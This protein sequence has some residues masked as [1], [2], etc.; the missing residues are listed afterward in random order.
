[1]YVRNTSQVLAKRLA[2]SRSFI[3]IVIGPRQTGKTTAIRQ[4]V[5]ASGR[6]YRVANADGITVPP[7][8]WVETEWMQARALATSD[9]PAILVLDEIQKV[10]GW[11]EVVKRLWDEDT[12]AG[13]NLLVVLS[14]SSSLLL[15]KGYAESLAGRF[16]LVR[17]THWSLTEMEEAFGY[18]YEDYLLFGGYPGASR[19]RDDYERWLEYM[20]DSIIEATISR[21]ILQME[22]VRKPALLR[23]LF[24]LGTHYSAQ[25]LSYRKVL[26]QLDDKGNVSTLAHY[27]RLLDDAGLLSGLTKFDRSEAKGAGS[28]PRFLVYDPALMTA[29]WSDPIDT[30]LND[31]TN[32]GH[33]VESAIGSYLLA[34]SQVRGFDLSWWR[35]GTSEVDFVARKGSRVYAIEVKSGRVRATGG[36]EKFCE[37]FE[38]AQPLLIG[39]ANLSCEDFLRGRALLF[40]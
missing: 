5:Q 37:R 38:G 26:G 12:W 30:L 39:D 10:D 33:L 31:P 15:K 21:D 18:S 34:Q 13:T 4:A 27:L 14:G 35:E 24:L 25:E 19:L 1:M 36:L 40:P 3:Q 16:E 11:S 23:S 20:R 8:A 6:P 7:L 28:S 32:R 29:A 9:T 22:E 17:S 2:E